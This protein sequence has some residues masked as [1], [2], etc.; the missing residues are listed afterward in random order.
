MKWSKKSE[1]K[2]VIIYSMEST[3]KTKLVNYIVK[4][5]SNDVGMCG[6]AYYDPNQEMYGEEIEGL[7]YYGMSKSY[8]KYIKSRLDEAKKSLHKSAVIDHYFVE[9]IHKK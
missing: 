7:R 9:Y 8:L 1:N 6:I 2:N 3:S 5:H 4:N